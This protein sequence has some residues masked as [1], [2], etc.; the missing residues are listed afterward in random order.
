MVS[1]VI[2]SRISPHQSKSQWSS[3]RNGLKDLSKL[4]EGEREG[5]NTGVADAFTSKPQPHF[6]HHTITLRLS[7]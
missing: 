4:C 6:R 5:E 7:T 3:Q 1:Y 2:D